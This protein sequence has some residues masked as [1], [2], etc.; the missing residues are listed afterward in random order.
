MAP[1][2]Y[3]VIFWYVDDEARCGGLSGKLLLTDIKFLCREDNFVYYYST[4]SKYVGCTQSL[5]KGSAW[6]A[7]IV[8]LSRYHLV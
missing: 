6:S 8:R 4:S 5:G 3:I 1:E 7:Q 2:Q